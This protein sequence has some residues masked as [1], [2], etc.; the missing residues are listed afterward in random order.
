MAQGRDQGQFSTWGDIGYHQRGVWP[1][2]RLTNVGD[3]PRAENLCFHL[4]HRSIWNYQPL[5]NESGSKMAEITRTQK[6]FY[7]S[8]FALI[9]HYG[10]EPPTGGRAFGSIIGPESTTLVE[11]L[12]IPFRLDT[13]QSTN[14]V[15]TQ[16]ARKFMSFPK[17][18][19]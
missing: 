9:R 13:V 4:D 15:L 19:L 10:R 11:G 5:D 16:Q 2:G 1:I 17:C 14:F 8:L 12:V 6:T 3:S 7:L 18:L